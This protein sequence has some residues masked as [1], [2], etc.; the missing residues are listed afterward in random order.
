MRISRVKS[1]LSRNEPVLITAL[2]FFD[3]SVY[4]L[5]SLMG[6]D[7][8]WLDLE[9]HATSVET[10]AT[11]IRAARVGV[12]DVIARPAKGEFMRM[13]RL[14]EAGAHG[15]MYPRC[16]TAEE[17][18]EIV[19]WGKFAPLGTRGFDGGNGDMPYCL[20]NMASYVEAANRETFLI[21]QLEDNTSIENAE[22]I[23]AVPGIDILFFGVGDFSV[24]N[25]IPGQ[26]NHPKI[27]DAIETV[28]KA[29]SRHGKV[30]GTPSF[31]ASHAG[32]LIDMGARFLSHSADL[33][34]VKNG[35]E[36]IQS[37]FGQ[38]GF[39]FERRD[40]SPL[41]SSQYSQNTNS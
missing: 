35:L 31:N 29:A 3:P 21:A 30:W 39:T 28:A 9:H 6:V 10:A 12:S 24:L 27:W 7:G 16:E 5:A 34:L 17:A 18:A 36:Q 19:K 26:F 2:H 14:L 41:Q 23:A 1:K 38:L 22:A 15:I 25:G 40:S 33:V 8:L 20:D 4:E 11:L 32:R 13:A 37:D